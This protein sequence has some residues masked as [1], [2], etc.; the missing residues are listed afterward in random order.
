MASE[1]LLD[2]QQVETLSIRLANDID[3][4]RQ[5]YLRRQ[6]ATFWTNAAFIL[7]GLFLS[8]GVSL[9][10]FYGKGDIVP[11]LGM[12]IFLLIGVQN[13]FPMGDKAEFYRLLVHESM[14]LLSDIS[15]AKAEDDLRLIN[16]RF[17]ILRKHAATALPRG[18][19]METVKDMYNELNASMVKN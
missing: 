8:A 13:A 15:F 4:F 7:I 2:K 10:S 12:S 14:N 5:T 19:G 17:Q 3:S 1:S 9:A 18:R 16:Q 6:Q 11:L